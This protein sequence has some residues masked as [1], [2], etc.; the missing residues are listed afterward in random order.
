M[1]S[2]SEK[3]EPIALPILLVVFLITTYYVCV[4]GWDLIYIFLSFTKAWGSNPD[5]L[6]K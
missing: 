6:H 3:L 5:V 4:V 2:V 1:F